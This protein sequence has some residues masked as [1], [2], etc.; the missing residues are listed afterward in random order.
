[1]NT[2]IEEVVHGIFALQGYDEDLQSNLEVIF[3]DDYV[4]FREIIENNYLMDLEENRN[5]YL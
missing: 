3:E 2:D 4:Q 1:L 5:S